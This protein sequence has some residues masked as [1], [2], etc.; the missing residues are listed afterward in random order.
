MTDQPLNMQTNQQLPS[1]NSLTNSDFQ[2]LILT[3]TNSRLYQHI[4]DPNFKRQSNQQL[5]INSD[6]QIL[7]LNNDQMAVVTKAKALHFDRQN[8]QQLTSTN[9]LTSSD[10][11]LLIS[12]RDQL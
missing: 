2:L 8:H 5:I 6:F 9:S 7:I 11:Q 3:G 12:D 4:N 1:V 10:F